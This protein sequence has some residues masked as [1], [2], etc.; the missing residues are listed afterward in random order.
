[1]R[2]RISYHKLKVKKVS[3]DINKT[4]GREFALK[5]LFQFFIKENGGLKEKLL[6]GDMGPDELEERLT[7]FRES[8]QDADEEHPN[9]MLDDG[10]WF[11]ANKLL[12]EV[13][14]NMED[15]E[16]IIKEETGK[17][18]LDTIEKVERSALLVGSAEL[19]YFETPFQVVINECVELA[20]KYGGASSGKFV[21]GVLDGIRSKQK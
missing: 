16:S 13:S 12:K 18:S 1:M 11:F 19:L 9:N 15:L 4:P 14:K 20:K 2:D 17:A 7:E 10:N 6:A 3:K 5:F 21:N 8:Y